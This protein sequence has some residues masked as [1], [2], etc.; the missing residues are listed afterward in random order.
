MDFSYT[1]A[2]KNLK[3]PGT[4]RLLTVPENI[5]TFLVIFEMEKICYTECVKE[6]RRLQCV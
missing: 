1:G 6:R 3:L 4:W 5:L 2:G